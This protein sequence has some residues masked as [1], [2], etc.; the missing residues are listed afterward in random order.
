MRDRSRSRDRKP[1]IAL[2]RAGVPVLALALL[3]A[4]GDD[5]ESRN[6][7]IEGYAPDTG[8][9][10]AERA[11]PRSGRIAAGNAAPDEAED[12]MLETEADPESL[13][14]SAQGYAVAPMDAA[15]GF[16]PT[17][18]RETAFAPTGAE[19]ENFGD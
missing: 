6:A 13:V 8:P 1:A 7:A 16:D 2:A 5:L 18:T 9:V 12:E 10:I 17:P 19:P 15:T 14:D 4:C 11:A 3:A